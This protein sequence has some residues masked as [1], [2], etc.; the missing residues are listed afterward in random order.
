MLGNVLT[1]WG[2]E[3]SSSQ[4]F[5]VCWKEFYTDISLRNE[6]LTWM[7]MG[8]WT[9][10]VLA[11]IK[12]KRNEPGI[13]VCFWTAV[14]IQLIPHG[15]ARA[16]LVVPALSG[17]YLQTASLT[18]AIDEVMGLATAMINVTNTAG[19]NGFVLLPSLIIQW[20][21]FCTLGVVYS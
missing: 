16:P 10:R 18:P 5:C 21:F 2:L 12:K 15:Q 14:I 13:R 4:I 6:Y 20:L 11:W 1:S 17:L 3:K 19:I 7:C 8:M 9:S